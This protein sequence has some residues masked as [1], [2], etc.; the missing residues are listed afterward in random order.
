MQN[1][2]RLTL[3]AAL[4]LCSTHASAENIKLGYLTDTSGPTQDISKIA[5]EGFTLY[6]DKINKSGGVDGRK[7]EV[8][9][10]DVGL[11]AA[12]AVATAQDLASQGAIAILGLP[13]SPVQLGVNTAMLRANVPVIAG[14]PSNI[15]IILPPAQANAFGTGIVFDVGGWAG[16]EL[17]RIASP[18][19]KTFVCTSLEGPGGVQTCKNSSLTAKKAGFEKAETVI[20]PITMRDLNSVAQRIAELKPDVVLMSIGR[21]RTL[22]MVPALNAAGY[23][24]VALSMEAGTGDDVVREVAK[25]NPEI[26]MWSYARFVSSGYGSG[27]QVAA[28]DDA[29]K[30]AGIK[31]W[32]TMHAG[33]WSLAMTVEAAAKGCPSPCT[34][35]KFQEALTKVNVDTGGL[36]GAPIRFS[37]ADHYGASTWRL[38][39]YNKETDKLLPVGDW[40]KYDSNVTK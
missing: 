7:F 37:E 4:A 35:Q 16:G 6:I 36:T 27:V 19:G 10:R 21:S 12:R 32:L 33:G 31:E 26:E 40:H 9:V 15:N 1:L 17:A 3:A 24:G 8:D 30:S 2:K 25:A 39:K 29:A 34:P 13:L 5:Y 38:L 18:K 20:F 14:Y 23:R 22:A 28:L 11:D